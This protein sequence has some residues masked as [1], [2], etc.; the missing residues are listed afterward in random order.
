MNTQILDKLKYEGHLQSY[1][2]TFIQKPS[3]TFIYEPILMEICINANIMNTQIFQ[4]M[5]NDLKGYMETSR[6]NY[7]LDLCSYGNFCPCLI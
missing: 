7:N 6:L 5:R 3:C 4:K 1:K 2:T